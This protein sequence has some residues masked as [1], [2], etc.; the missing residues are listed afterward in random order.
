M[1]TNI[2]IQNFRGIAELKIEST[3]KV[4]LIIGDNN[5]GKTSLLEAIFFLFGSHRTDVFNQVNT[6]RTYNVPLS[7]NIQP[8]WENI[9][10]KASPQRRFH[11]EA[12]LDGQ[13]LVVDAQES[14]SNLIGSFTGEKAQSTDATLSVSHLNQHSQIVFRNNGQLEITS[15]VP[16]ILP[17]L[18]YI[19]P[20]FNHAVAFISDLKKTGHYE[21]CRDALRQLFHDTKF[22]LDIL[23]ESGLPVLYARS[24]DAFLPINFYGDGL[25]R[26]VFLLAA[27]VQCRDGYLIIDEVENGI[28]HSRLASFWQQLLDFAERFNVQLFVSSHSYECLQKFLPVMEERKTDFAILKLIF[29]NGKHRV[30]LIDA[31]KALR[32]V[33]DEHEIR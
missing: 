7:G 15:P 4:N 5:A 33:G 20:H 12:Q 9:F 31:E 14:Q 17:K 19:S 2:H 30:N 32:L 25:Q 28:H 3:R 8:L 6:L 1:I 18:F 13:P 16:V 26:I 21:A 23:I 29:Q 27:V 10:N 24:S 11:I 22:D